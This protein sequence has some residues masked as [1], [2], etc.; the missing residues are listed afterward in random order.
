MFSVI[1]ELFQLDGLNPQLVRKGC[2]LVL[3]VFQRTG[4]CYSFVIRCRRDLVQAV[5]A[6][7]RGNGE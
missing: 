7:R 6:L 4:E 1:G 5:V 2:R 3:E